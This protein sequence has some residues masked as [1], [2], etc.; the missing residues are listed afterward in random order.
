MCLRLFV[1][2]DHQFPRFGYQRNRHSR[3]NSSRV[4]RP[5][6]SCFGFGSQQT[7]QL[8]CVVDEQKIELENLRREKK[9]E[10]AASEKEISSLR[11]RV[12]ALETQLGL[13][14]SAN[15]T[16][17][18]VGPGDTE[19][20]LRKIQAQVSFFLNLRD[21]SYI[22]DLFNKHANSATNLITADSVRNVMRDIG[23]QM[24]ADEA[25]VLFETFDTD[26]NGG[27]DL[28]EFTKAIKHPSKVEQWANTLPLSKLL[29]R[30]LS[31]K[32]SD[33]PLREVSRLSSDELRAL[34]KAFTEGLLTILSDSLS[35]LKKCYTEMDRMTDLSAN[36]ASSKFQTFKM[37]SGSVEDFHS[38]LHGRV[39]E[40]HAPAIN[41]P[42]K[43]V[44]AAPLSRACVP[45]HPHPN[46]SKGVEEEHCVMAGCDDEFVSSNYGVRTTPR[47][48]YDIATGR[49]ACPPE[50]MLDKKGRKVRD[51]RPIAELKRLKLV[52]RAGLEDVEI[53][54]VVRPQPSSC[55][56][57]DSCCALASLC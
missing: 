53:V 32:E 27:L 43:L 56:L 35:E 40:N 6:M 39:G 14:K 17:N 38:G 37:S 3:V 8:R 7:T 24:T 28:Q 42:A 18:A 52:Q 48:E 36:D 9:E 54:A 41:T 11:L 1:L 31:F 57:R 46:L 20:L 15:D 49:R 21:Q 51:V 13:C 10:A 45:G 33:D 12:M 30:C 44:Y 26:E 47:K 34:T 19:N 22:S 50:D 25:A 2:Y 4:T 29:A 16:A 55:S 23:V 5:E